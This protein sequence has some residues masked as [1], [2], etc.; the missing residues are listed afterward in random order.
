MFQFFIQSVEGFSSV[1]N[2]LGTL[3]HYILIVL[4]NMLTVGFMKCHEIR[5]AHPHCLINE[6]ESALKRQI[7]S[8]LC[9]ILHSKNYKIPF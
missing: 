7:N 8:I 1:I 6:D 3:K 4:I 2:L 9:G 5:V